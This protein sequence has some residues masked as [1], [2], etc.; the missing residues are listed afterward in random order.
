VASSGSSK[1]RLQRTLIGA[2]CAVA[3][4]GC[5]GDEADEPTATTATDAQTTEASALRIRLDRLVTRLLTDRGLDPKVA[6]CALSEL[7]ESVPD[8][9]LESA[10]A[11]IRKTGAAPPEVIAAAAA[12]G[13]ACGRP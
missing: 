8:A 11:A 6:E 5:G 2:A 4:A 13:E 12:A 9:E 1:R 7:A 3:L 10:I